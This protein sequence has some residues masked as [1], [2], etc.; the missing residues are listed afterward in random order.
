MARSEPTL[1]TLKETGKAGLTRQVKDY[2]K[3]AEKIYP[4]Y[5]VRNHQS[6][7]SDVGRP[8]YEIGFKRIIWSYREKDLPD[9]ADIRDTIIFLEIELHETVYI[10]LKSPKWRGKLNK[11]QQAHKDRIER[12]GGQYHIVTTI[13]E[14]H[15][16][17]TDRGYDKIQL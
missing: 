14:L 2:L 8:D 3:L 11:Y 13:Y 7:G 5:A 12:A 16:I 15:K 17:F 6:M 4:I 9:Y 10:E 1:D